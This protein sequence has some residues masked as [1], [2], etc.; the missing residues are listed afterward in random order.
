M[1]TWPCSHSA[2]HLSLSE[3]HPYKGCITR[4]VGEDSKKLVLAQGVALPLGVSIAM[5]VA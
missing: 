1:D 3:M 5:M 2:S 4:E